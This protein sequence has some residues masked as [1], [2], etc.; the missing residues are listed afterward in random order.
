MAISSDRV[1]RKLVA[2]QASEGKG[3]ESHY[4][5]GSYT[6]L[7]LAAVFMLIGVMT[8][9]WLG[10]NSP[11][12]SQGRLLPDFTIQPLVN[13]QATTNPGQW[14]G[15]KTLLYLWS[16]TSPA[17]QENVDQLQRF[18]ADHPEFQLETVAFVEKGG[19]VVETLAAEVQEFLKTRQL[20]WPVYVDTQ[21]KAT[22]ELTLLM[23][24]GSFGFPTALAVDSQ[25]KLLHICEGTKPEDWQRLTD[26][27]R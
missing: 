20:E 26:V 14:I 27:I 17:C 22:M 2:D 16:P 13:V 24:Y 18:L 1:E 25:G 15:R 3:V 10:T 9:A 7:G 6:V 23:P 11:N 4:Q 5:P 19:L 8:L 21:G 12:R